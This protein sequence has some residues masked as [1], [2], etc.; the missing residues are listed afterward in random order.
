MNKSILESRLRSALWGLFAGDALAMPT[1][2]FYGGQH[3]IQA[4]YGSVGITDYTAPVQNL[5]G[6][7][8][9]KSNT[10][11]GGRGRYERKN[12]ISIIGDFICH[13]KRD[14]WAPNKSIHYH[15]TLQRGE[16]TLEAQLCRVLMASIVECDGM[17]DQDAF[18]QAYVSFMTT[19]GSHND[20]Y[21]STCHRMFFANKVFHD[22]PLDECPDNDAHNV[23]TLDGM[24]L[25]TIVALAYACQPERF[26]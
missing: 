9:N 17:F 13:G 25:P 26:R 1:H 21:A 2:W 20:T 6:S 10:N 19:P 15:A 23:D 18:R 16:C 24:V 4:T 22:R 11:G 3:Q 5:P 14:L 12:G 8:L 7:I